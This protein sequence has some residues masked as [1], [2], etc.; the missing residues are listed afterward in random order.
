MRFSL[1]SKPQP[2]KKSTHATSGAASS[3]NVSSGPSQASFRSRHHPASGN[4]SGSG[5]KARSRLKGL[6]PFGKKNKQSAT[7]DPPKQQGGVQPDHGA[8]ETSE[9]DLTPP[10]SPGPSSDGGNP[11]YMNHDTQHGTIRGGVAREKRGK[12]ICACDLYIHWANGLSKNLTNPPPPIVRL[13]C[14]AFPSR[15]QPPHPGL[16]L[17]IPLYQVSSSTCLRLRLFEHHVVCQRQQL[18]AN[19][20]RPITIA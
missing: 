15:L 13:A 1:K 16:S 20:P 17:L 19:L 11:T 10:S 8:S 3:H 12:S 6:W 2:S 4:T 7:E 5:E 9:R 18:V 14:T